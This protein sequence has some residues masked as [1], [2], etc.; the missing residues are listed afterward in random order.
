MK[1]NINSK[2]SSDRNSRR[3]ILPTVWN[4]PVNNKS[5]NQYIFFYG[6]TWIL[7]IIS[8]LN[9]YCTKIDDAFCCVIRKVITYFR[10]LIAVSFFL[11][12]LFVW[13]FPISDIYNIP[14]T[15]VLFIG[16][17]RPMNA[18]K[19]CDWHDPSFFDMITIILVLICVFL[20]F[21]FV[22]PIVVIITILWM[23]MQSAPNRF[24]S[25]WKSLI[26]FIAIFNCWLI[27]LSLN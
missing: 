11:S 1:Q 9:C 3:A 25:P 26:N 4:L 22:I 23:V 27:F 19:K 14:I 18:R 2:S 17:I 5:T 10:W 21:F 13:R 12:K 16:Y 7:T 8:F 24:L 15:C 6:R 20:F